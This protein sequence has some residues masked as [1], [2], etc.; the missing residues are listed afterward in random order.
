MRRIFLCFESAFFIS[1][2]PYALH[3]DSRGLVEDR[4][5]LATEDACDNEGDSDDERDDCDDSGAF[6]AGH[7][8]WA[9]F[10]S[11]WIYRVFIVLL[12]F[13]EL[14]TLPHKFYNSPPVPLPD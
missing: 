6:C 1:A 7:L 12:Q 4:D 8:I 10:N 11:L 5:R 13:H 14:P 2:Y 9:V 3:A